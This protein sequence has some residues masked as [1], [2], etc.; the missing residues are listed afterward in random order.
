MEKEEVTGSVLETLETGAYEVCVAGDWRAVVD[1]EVVADLR[2]YRSYRGDSVRDLLRA[3]RNK[4]CTST[5]LSY[6]V[7]ELFSLYRL[8]LEPSPLL[9][10]AVNY[11]DHNWRQTKTFLLKLVRSP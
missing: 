8:G 4:V 9:P 10:L 3:L 11:I 6:L 7:L 5:S 2:K 1:D